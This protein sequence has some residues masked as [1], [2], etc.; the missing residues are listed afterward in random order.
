MARSRRAG[1]EVI[2][3]YTEVEI[4]K[5]TR[6]EAIFASVPLRTDAARRLRIGTSATYLVFKLVQRLSRTWRKINGYRVI[7][8]ANERAA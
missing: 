8:V 1:G 2:A 5:K 4:D 6:C 3:E 7:G